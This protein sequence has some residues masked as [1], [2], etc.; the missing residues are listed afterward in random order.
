MNKKTSPPK[1]LLRFFR[2]Y[3]HPDYQE[4]IE[5]DLRERFERKAT[6]KGVGSANWRLFKD[7]IRLFRPGI[8]KPRMTQKPCFYGLFKH[9]LMLTF[10]LINRDRT[11]AAL[12]LS[13]LALGIAA[14]AI[15]FQYVRY[16]KSYDQFHHNNPN[17]YRINYKYFLDG[18]LIRSM[19]AT[20]PRIAPFMKEKLPEVKSYVRI[21]PYG[22]YG[23][24]LTIAAG[25]TKFRERNVLFVDPDFLRI[26]SFPL[27][28]GDDKSCLNGIRTMVITE[29]IAKK[30]F[31][32]QDPLGKLVTIDSAEGTYTITGVA[33]DVPPNSHIQFDFLISYKTLDWWYEGE[34]E[35]SWYSHYF[36]S[37]VLLEPRVD[38]AALEE[39]FAGIFSDERY[40]KNKESNLV[41]EF[42]LQQVT[43]IHFGSGLEQELNPQN[44][45]DAL[46]IDFLFLVGWLILFIALINYVNLSTARAIKRAK[47]VGVKK[48]MGAYRFQ[49]VFQFIVESFM[50]NSLAGVLA[51]CFLILG[52]NQFN[53]FVNISLSPDYLWDAG[54]WLILFIIWALGALAAGL[55]PA[56]VLSS[57]KP[58]TALKDNLIAGGSGLFR[59]VLVAFQF[60]ASVSLIIC[61]TIVFMQQKH[62]KDQ[63]KGFNP[64]D[65]IV[66]RGPNE[67]E[68]NEQPAKQQIFI[69]E[70]SNYPQVK[71]VTR[72]D[73]IPGQVVS[74]VASIR[75]QSEPVQAT[76]SYNAVSVGYGYFSTFDIDMI[77]GRAFNPKFTGDSFPIVLNETGARALGFNT[78]D[79]VIGQRVKLGSGNLSGM[80]I[81]VVEDFNQVSPK[82][83]ISPMLFYMD[84]GLNYY[85]SIKHNG[86]FQIVLQKVEELFTDLYPYDPF[87]Y[88]FMDEFYNRQYINEDDL[89]KVITIFSGLAIFI[90]CLGLFGLTSYNATRRTKEIGIRK[91]FGATAGNII[92]L[93]TREFMVLIAFAN[94]VAW[95]IIYYIMNEWLNNFA[96]RITISLWIFLLSG[97]IVL[98]LALL[99]VSSITI[100]TARSNPTQS[101]RHE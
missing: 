93:L 100:K 46:T 95:P 90:A 19:A 37:Y 94:M 83:P 92:Q 15:I 34:A 47:E 48:T 50:I 13:G 53:Q 55:Y 38:I 25:S 57:F 56:S 11:Y 23:R 73:A 52:I 99:S 67:L 61:T 60:G 68:G 26:F 33:K 24:D 2:W 58:L 16:E 54:F 44:Q 62:L 35:S 40:K 81:G 5:G 80:I 89:S 12:N 63:D 14:F 98:F 42:N 97:S 59:K 74:D 27:V 69:N 66:V 43:E 76:R 82:S 84:E 18:D 72:S 22:K 65:L 17:I 86:D 91:V 49:L 32:D 29:S 30:Y 31:K 6:E 101:L 96:S 71:S 20:P 78:P 28:T 79:Q 77:A 85:Y 21:H 41:Q 64:G 8:I 70:L 45:A 39:K 1:Y 3:C 87:D 7:V 51:V 10:R 36:H 88:F 9:N 4:D 75:K